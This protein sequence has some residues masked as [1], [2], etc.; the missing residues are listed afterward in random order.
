MYLIKFFVCC[1][2]GCGCNVE[3][4]S[5]IHPI[6]CD[7]DTPYDDVSFCRNLIINCEYICKQIH[8]CINIV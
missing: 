6:Q 5:L 1:L 4:L 2:F 8:F 7:S 3:R